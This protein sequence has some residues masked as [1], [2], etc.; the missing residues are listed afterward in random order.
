MFQIT[1]L[2]FVVIND[3]KGAMVMTGTHSMS[4]Y[5]LLEICDVVRVVS[6]QLPAKD[7]VYTKFRAHMYTMLA[8]LEETV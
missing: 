1:N 7:L 5:A 2:P 6:W 3:F 4:L 8:P